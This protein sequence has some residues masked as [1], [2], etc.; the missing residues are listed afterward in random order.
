MKL[1]YYLRGLGIGILITVLVL[2]IASLG[3]KKELTDEEII[4]RAEELG[5]VKKENTGSILDSFPDSAPD[6][7]L[8]GEEDNPQNEDVPGAG[9][10]ADGSNLPA[11]EE[12]GGE[13][14]ADPDTSQPPDSQRPVIA[15]EV[16]PGEYSDKISKK[17]MEAGLIEDAEDFNRYLVDSGRDDLI[18]VGTHLIPQGAS[19]EEISRILSEEEGDPES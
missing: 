16:G 7:P 15:V 13:P 18:A 19:Y 10:D 4:A 8:P 3:E 9:G 1:K 17:L 11:G 14:Q 5:M 2:T 6:E 12:G